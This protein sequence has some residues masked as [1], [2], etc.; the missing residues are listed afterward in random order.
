[1]VKIIQDGTKHKTVTSDY[2]LFVNIPCLKQMSDFS[3]FRIIV[4]LFFVLLSLLSFFLYFPRSLFLFLA[5]T[6][7]YI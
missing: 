4:R 1:M 5:F 6:E 2:Y 3:I 7:T